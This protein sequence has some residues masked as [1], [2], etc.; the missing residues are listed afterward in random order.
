MFRSVCPET[1]QPDWGSVRIAWRGLA[2]ERRRVRDYLLA[3]RE[4]PSFHEDAVER[5]FV[6]V[7][8]AARAAALTVDGRFLRRGGIDI[9]P[10]RSTER[11][12]APFFR[13]A[14]Q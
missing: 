4:H 7:Q 3:Y 11:R 13:L 10:F 6:D 5:I 9:N 14:R 2:I 1:G 12:R 8:R